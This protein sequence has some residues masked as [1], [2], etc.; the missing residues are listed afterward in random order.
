MGLSGPRG[1]LRVVCRDALRVTDGGG[2]V[3]Q[4]GGLSDQRGRAK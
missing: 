4:M 1:G 3:T 2:A